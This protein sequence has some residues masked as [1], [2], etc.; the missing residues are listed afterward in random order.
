MPLAHWQSESKKRNEIVT[1]ES[2]KVPIRPGDNEVLGEITER[3]K[4][5][6]IGNG[7]AHNLNSSPD[8]ATD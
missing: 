1:V 7:E 3:L 2:A 5:I 4:W 6:L 8:H